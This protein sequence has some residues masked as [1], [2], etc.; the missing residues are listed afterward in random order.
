MKHLLFAGFMLV[1]LF[2]NA[3]YRVVTVPLKH[4]NADLRA[5]W[6][7]GM[8][9]PQFSNIDLNHDSL[10]DLFAFDRVG[11]KVMTYLR[12]STADSD[13]AFE[14]APQY[15]GLFPPE[16]NSWALIRD[17]NNDGI[18]DIFAHA[19]AGI[20]VYKGRL[21]NNELHFDSVSPLLMYTDPPYE[22]NIWTNIDDIPVITDVNFDGDLDI[23]TYG[24]WGATI[25]YYENQTMEHPG[26][27]HYTADSLKYAFSTFCW[28]NFAQN[29]A[30]NSIQLNV[31]CKGGGQ[32]NSAVD[33]SRHA[34][35]A[36]YSFDADNDHDIDLLNGNIGYDNLAFIRNCG[37]SSYADACSWDSLYPSCNTS[38]RMP[39]YPAGYGVNVSNDGFEDLLIAPNARAG[40]RDVNNVMYYRNTDNPSCNFEFVA[41]SFLVQHT[42]DLGTDSKPYFFDFNGDGLM[43]IM[44]GNYGYFRP[45]NTYKSTITILLNNGTS[46]S[47]SYM[48]SDED[49]HNFSSFGL[50]AMHP[51]FG[52]LDGDGAADML[53]GELNGYLNFFKNT[54]VSQANFQSMTTPQ[55]FGLDVGQY[56]APF[57]YDVNGDSLNDLVVGRKDGKLTYYWNYGTQA[58]PLFSQDS[59]NTNFGQVNVTVPGYTEGYSTPFIT[60]D[61]VG[62]MILYSGSMRGAVFKYLVDA[63]NL[64]N[65]AFTLL[66]SDVMKQ[67]VGSKATFSMADLNGDG[68]MEYVL[69]NSRGGLLLY[70]DSLW[71]ESVL[72]VAVTEVPNQAAQLLLYPNPASGYFVC[73]LNSGSFTNAVVELY[74]VL[75]EVIPAPKS[76]AA[77]GV[78]VTTTGLQPGLYFIR[79]TDAGRSYTGRVLV[80]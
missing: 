24:T 4:Y 18:P 55:Y 40:S 22:V 42:L 50:I 38:I 46:S 2:T 63:S 33:E 10:P 15:E 37:D 13:T 74:N 80:R 6:Q 59:A 45:F 29:A 8:N 77:A 32:V 12:K 61:S 69:G 57:I 30:S 9:S 48:V 21:L 7:G 58:S 19:N 78:T 5:P 56:S 64:S 62:Q 41:D 28:G 14:Y 60:R 67:D 39:T 35:N 3:Q 79:I 11:D 20:M 66:D 26:D 71:D 75:G 23:L 72:P 1:T 68:H 52:D 25:E 17:F 31:S 44:A 36:I 16:L 49:Y 76:M 43:D 34:G 73:K 65:G 70:S 47:P 51:A 54:G 53:V 27:I